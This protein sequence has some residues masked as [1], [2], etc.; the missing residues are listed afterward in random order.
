[1]MRFH[2]LVFAAAM[3]MAG[4]AASSSA[5]PQAAAPPKA[6]PVPPTPGASAAVSTLRNV[7]L[8]LLM[9]QERRAVATAARVKMSGDEWIVPIDGR[10]QIEV[11]PP[12]T[13][14]PHVCEATITHRIGSQPA[15]LS[16]IDAWTSALSPPLRATQFRQR[17]TGPDGVRTTSIWLG[18][19]PN[20]Q[21]A[22][23]MTELK[24]PNGQPEKGDLDQ[25]SLTMTLT[26]G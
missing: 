7:C 15:I 21:L 19:I 5:A 2:T 20:G 11:F 1:M 12:D 24:S 18:A 9:G 13:A 6:T 3:A 17:S 8:P 4:I 23:V 14:N 10:R 26:P 16:A 22:V 25:T